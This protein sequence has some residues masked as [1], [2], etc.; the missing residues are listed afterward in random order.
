MPSAPSA[1]AVS[2]LPDHVL[3]FAPIGRDGELTRRFLEGAGVSNILC[4]SMAELCDAFEDDGA[5]AL[6]LTEEALDAP[7]FARLVEVLDQQAYW[8]D[9]PVLL[10]TGGSPAERPSSAIRSIETLRNVTLLDR[11]IRIAVVLS[12]IRSA[13]RSRARQYEVLDLVLKL[14]Q[15]RADAEAANRL[16][17]EFLATLS[18]ELRTP[19]NAIVGWTSML[20]RGQ[21]D[22]QRL[23]HVFEA[24]DRNAQAQAQLIADVLDVSRI[25]TGKLEVR[26]DKV[27]FCDLVERAADTV[28]LAASAKGI[29][30]SIA[31]ES[32]GCWVAG[33][34]DRLQ[35]IVWN[36]LSNAVKFTPRGGTIRVSVSSEGEK[37]V[38]RIADT[39]AGID[40][41]FIPHVFERFRQAD[42][43]S[44]RVHGGL[45]LGLAIVKHLV[46]LHG[47]SVS[48]HSDGVGF[49]AEFRVLLPRV[50]ALPAP[51]RPAADAS[52]AQFAFPGRSIL[53]VD[54]DASTREVVAATLERAG[55]HVDVA[56]SAAEGLSALHMRLPDLL[57]ADLA[58]PAEDGLSL[59][60]R[61]RQISDRA[62]DLPSI[63]LSAYA[64]Q[65][66]A[67]AA[68]EAGFTAF[69]QKPAR[70]ESLLTL[71]SSLLS[72]AAH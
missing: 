17:D 61:V 35:Q 52:S 11:P 33:D 45:G 24:L 19:L 65:Q 16:K 64:D 56:S 9:I 53:V 14:R 36:L 28:R 32:A 30:L 21:V 63:A 59:I 8:S 57:I 70:A 67:D 66:S 40:P 38:L 29:D 41:A 37:V 1:S 23:P 60:R 34:S 25:V 26:V 51:A 55:A 39:G 4:D 6:L 15:A 3:I 5:G 27:D 31:D 22:T 46:E 68:L 50:D 18:H 71:V 69:L 48:A 58:M 10:F 7:G 54:D 13:L 12:A 43:T 47:G 72:P 44:T 62:K 42:Q 20:T 49:G 2:T